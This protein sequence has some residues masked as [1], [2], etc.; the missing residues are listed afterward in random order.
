MAGVPPHRIRRRNDLAPRP[1][2]KFVLY[3]MVA[4]R[5]LQS[6]YSLQRAVEWSQELGRPIVILE[7]LRC[8]YPWASHRFHRFVLDGMRDQR[9]SLHPTSALYYPYVEPKPDAGKGLLAALATDAC[10]VVT[11]DFPC[12]MIPAMTAAAAKQVPVLL[13]D[14]DSNGVLPQRV[15]D[16]EFPTAYSFR[17]Y[18]QKTLPDYLGEV[19][20][21]DPLVDAVPCENLRLPKKIVD[22][23]PAADPALLSGDSA[24]LDLLPIDAS[25]VPAPLEGGP[26][27][28]LKQLQTFLD[29]RLTG[30]SGDRNQPE[31]D[32]T[33]ELS[34]YLHF[35]H[36]SAHQ[37]LDD[38][39]HREEWSLENLPPTANGKRTGWWQ[40]G[41]NAEPFLDQIVT[42]REL[43]YNMCCQRGDYDSYDSLPGWAQQTLA[44]HA[45]DPR[46]YVYDLEQF[47]RA[48]THDSLWNAAQVQLVREGKI[49][50]YLRMLWGKKILE[51]TDSP[52]TALEVM[53]ELNN[54]YA[55]DGRNPN[56]YSGIFWVLGRY[57]RAW[58]PERP[59]FGKI[60]YMTSQNTARKVS[61]RNYIRE[62][63]SLRPAQDF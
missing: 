5:R 17:R 58:G 61:V 39:L 19:P 50:N 52:R 46:E 1:E 33:S 34:P 7:A 38:L 10:V 47:E 60:R 23:W 8:G 31:R 15:P 26:A 48:Q 40:V 44:D 13:E 29:A 16:R 59:I 63:S 57:D 22:R 6:N 11:D 43:G 51:W 4:N 9:A 55:L 28:A 27:S 56:S 45:G 20:E 24:L 49:H 53:I 41:P 21:E 35:G 54:K 36:I 30:Y 12:F 18:L 2:G 32:V 42:W 3:W 37:V 25:V 62:Y 14:V